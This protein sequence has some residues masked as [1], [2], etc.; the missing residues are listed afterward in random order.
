MKPRKLF[1]VALLF[2]YLLWGICLLTA[3][4]FSSRDVQDIWNILLLPAMYY[5]IGI[6]FWFIP[7]SLLA[8]GMWI[9]SKNKSVE[10]LRKLGLRAPVI[11]SGLL[12]IEY[13]II[14]LVNYL[15]SETGEVIWAS[16]SGDATMQF[17]ALL[18]TSSLLV[19]YLLVGIALAIFKVLK[20]KKLIAENAHL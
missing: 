10:S 8:I 16:E 4:V 1:G 12:A 14:V 15:P 6:I 2:P 3:N 20:S 19:G 11:L 18:I 5:V 17:L 7:Y 9:W 13:S